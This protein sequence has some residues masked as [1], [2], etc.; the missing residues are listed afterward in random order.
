MFFCS[1][2]CFI[3]CSQECKRERSRILFI[4]MKF[5]YVKWERDTPAHTHT[6]E[7][8][9]CK[10]KLE[11]WQSIK[12]YDNT[13]CVKS[14]VYGI[15]FKVNRISMCLIIM[16]NNY[17][18]K[19]NVGCCEFHGNRANSHNSLT[20]CFQLTLSQQRLRGCEVTSLGHT[21]RFGK[22][23]TVIRTY[24]Q[25]HVYV[26]FERTD[27]GKQREKTQHVTQCRTEFI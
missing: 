6:Q 5:K 10:K 8:N 19:L 21:P 15:S 20:K 17:G 27:A 13:F 11:R 4:L 24:E 16:K 14:K 9:M 3:Y 7:R 23:V 25:T 2:L 22:Y 12:V 1:F 26:A 18:S